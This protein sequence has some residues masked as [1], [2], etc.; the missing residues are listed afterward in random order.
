M[1]LVNE[2]FGGDVKSLGYT[3]EGQKATVGVMN[4][5]EYEFGT[6]VA[7]RMTIIQGKMEALLPGELVANV[8][9]PGEW[10][11]VP[12]NTKFKVNVVVPTSY[13]CEF[14]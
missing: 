8:Y 9:G 11:D 7:E 1:I 13:L 2:Y 10:F 14:K 6:G 12:E 4:E 5:G 3:S